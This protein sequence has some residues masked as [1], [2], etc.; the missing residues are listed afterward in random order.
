MGCR[1][2]ISLETSTDDRTQVGIQPRTFSLW[3]HWRS[4][5]LLWSNVSQWNWSAHPA[6]TQMSPGSWE[7]LYLNGPV[8]RRQLPQRFCV[9][10]EVTVVALLQQ[11]LRWDAAADT[12]PPPLLSG[13]LQGGSG[14]SAK[15]TGLSR[16]NSS[17]HTWLICHMQMFVINT[18][19]NGPFAATFSC[20]DG[21]VWDWNVTTTATNVPNNKNKMTKLNPL[22]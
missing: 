12:R 5:A 10:P 3:A 13:G 18:A 22:F 8:S 14:I 4:E 7:W 17:G 20:R 16:R 11:V 2:D 21:L 15:C 19:G 6:H 1:M 9:W